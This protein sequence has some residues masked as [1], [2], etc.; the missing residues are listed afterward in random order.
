MGTD[1]LALL[2]ERAQLF[3]NVYNFKNNPHVPLGCNVWS[4][5][6]LDCGYKQSEALENYETAEKINR[7]FHE[8][9]QF[10]AD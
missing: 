4:W 5:Q 2:K 3:D 10:K 6:V 1:T 7:E 8:R 9:Y